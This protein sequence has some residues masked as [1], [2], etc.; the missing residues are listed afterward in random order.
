MI[1]TKI[2]IALGVVLLG[3]ACW[4]AAIGVSAATEGLL[5]VFALLVLVGGGN[6]L[7]GRSAPSRRPLP[8]GMARTPAPGAPPERQDDQAASDEEDERLPL[9]GAGPATAGPET[10]A[11]GEP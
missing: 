1:A 9:E 10:A 3:V 2:A 7:A 4:M 8:A 11:P 5:T 6:Y